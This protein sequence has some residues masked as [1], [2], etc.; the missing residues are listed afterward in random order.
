MTASFWLLLSIVDRVRV[1][2]TKT[3]NRTTSALPGETTRID[4][5]LCLVKLS[6][7][8]IRFIDITDLVHVSPRTI[9]D[10]SK[11]IATIAELS[12]F[13]VQSISNRENIVTVRRAYVLRTL[14]MI[15]SS[16]VLETL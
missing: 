14:F 1:Q 12:H 2:F 4:T 8:R 10:I 16:M 3:G 9:A 6:I 7:V 13:I 5:K 15:V 11:F